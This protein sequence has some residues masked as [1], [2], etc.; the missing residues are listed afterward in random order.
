MSRNAR[1]RFYSA[2]LLFSQLETVLSD[3][4][5]VTLIQRIL[6]GYETAANHLVDCYG[7]SVYR[8]LA[9]YIR[10]LDDREDLIQ[11]MFITALTRIHQVKQ[12]ERLKSWPLTIIYIDVGGRVVA[13]D[14]H[15]LFLQSSELFDRL[16]APLLR[17]AWCEN[18]G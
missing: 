4:M 9:P 10:D 7:P 18:P 17:G 5:A 15:R 6:E 11:E 12:P 2:L 14:G 16:P 1:Y 13:T 3:L 8:R